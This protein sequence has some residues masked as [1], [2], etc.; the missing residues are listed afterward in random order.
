MRRIK[1]RCFAILLL[2]WVLPLLAEQPADATAN[3]DVPTIVNFSGTLADVNGKPLVGVTG[4]TFYLYKEQQGGAPLW[5]ET[6][7]VQPDKHGNYTAQLGATAAEGLPTS[8]F[9]S[10]EARWL[11]VQIANQTEQPRVLL[12]AV[13][14]A[15]KAADASTIGG[16]PPSAFVRMNPEDAAPSGPPASSGGASKAF[17]VDNVKNE[18]PETLLTVRTT[19]GTTNF[20]PIWTAKSQILNSALFQAGGKVGLGT[21][22]PASLLDVNGTGTFR[23]TLT[24]LPNGSDPVLAVKTAQGIPFSITN[25]GDLIGHFGDFEGLDGSAPVF[26]VNNKGATGLFAN[27]A[28]TTGI[29]LEGSAGASTGKTT[30]ILGI[31]SSPNGTGVLALGQGESRTGGGIIGCCPVGLWGDTSSSAAGAAGLVG[32]AD[33][34]RAIYLQNN[35]PSGV[36]TAFMFQGA[37][38]KLA[39]V[40]GGAAGACVVDTNGDLGCHGSKSAYVD[41]DHGR[42]QVA[43][44]AVEA[45]QNWFEDF[46][47]AQ[48]ANGAATVKL[49]PT[50]AQTVSAASNYRVF[51]TP[52]GDC[53]GLYVDRKSAWEFEVRELGGGRSNV[54]FDY[55]IVALRRGYEDVR[56]E[57]KTEMMAKMKA[58]MPLSPA[59]RWTP[60]SLRSVPPSNAA[61][62]PSTRLAAQRQK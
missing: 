8:L 17:A 57:D 6:Q 55:R 33:D 25:G 28:G 56:L 2:G 45:P 37:S 50:F 11:G 13:P 49:D 32:T 5:M 19:G 53:H 27:S 30:G 21:T 9:A 61:L 40:A 10:G 20:L 36:P 38:G 60:P 23:D 43:L 34:A 18:Q 42:R 62:M 24:L 16:L 41:V 59:T 26:V 47:S 52:S 15:L 7:N 51:L 4:V 54:A 35:S 3:A 39:L 22:S 1:V 46:G 58:S 44:Y 14:Y 29:G 48:L 12:M 31:A